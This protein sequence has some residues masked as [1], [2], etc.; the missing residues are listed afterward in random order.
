MRILIYGGF[1]MNH[2]VP[3]NMWF[4]ILIV[5]DLLGY[6]YG[7]TNHSTKKEIVKGCWRE[8]SNMSSWDLCSFS[9]P[10]LT[11]VLFSECWKLY[12]TEY[13]PIMHWKHTNIT[14][15]QTFDLFYY[16]VIWLCILS[17]YV[18]IH[19]SICN[20]IGGLLIVICNIF[21]SSQH[22]GMNI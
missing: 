6:L 3:G 5:L 13:F 9:V 2:N 12:I 19:A 1:L 22:K 21:I 7:L 11:H 20:I 10:L 16:V 17:W 8:T 18:L 4:S 15:D 14:N